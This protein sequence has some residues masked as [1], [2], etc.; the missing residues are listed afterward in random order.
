MAGEPFIPSVEALVNR[1]KAL[2]VYE[3]WQLSKQAEAERKKYHDKW[4][5][6]RS[7]SGKAV[8]VLLTPVMPHTATRHRT[9]RWIGYT[10]IWNFLDYTALTLPVSTVSKDLDPVV[11]DHEPWNDFDAWIKTLYDL[12]LMA[13]HPINL[14]IVGR[15]LEEEKVLGAAVAI[16]RAAQVKDKAAEGSGSKFRL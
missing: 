12:D 9:C 15:K 16:E 13:G 5:A 3:Y 14:Q 1:G 10:Q 4:N 11:F 7:P 8:D 6:A 2:S